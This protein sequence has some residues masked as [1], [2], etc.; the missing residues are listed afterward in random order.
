MDDEKNITQTSEES[1]QDDSLNEKQSS[2][3]EEDNPNSTNDNEDDETDEGIE[4]DDTED[5]EENLSTDKQNNSSQNSHKQSRAENRKFAQLRREQK[6]NKDFTQYQKGVKETLGSINPYTKSEIKTP[7]D[8]EDYL[9][10]KEMDSKGLDPTDTADYIKYM[11]EKNAEK[12][13]KEEEQKRQEEAKISYQNE[14]ST[15]KA[16]YP[17][18]DIEQLVEENEIW[19]KI[20]TSQVRNGVPILEAYENALSLINDETNKKAQQLADEKAKKVVQNSIASAGS[21]TDG[22]EGEASQVDITKMSDKEFDEYWEKKKK[23]K[24]E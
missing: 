21:L 10:M 14:I 13:Q 7:S 18:I 24:F 22:E 1:V 15:F 8:V 2:I 4:F 19:G 11:R 23:E 12:I 17:N 9:A 6:Q 20:I 3:T 5:D 16:K